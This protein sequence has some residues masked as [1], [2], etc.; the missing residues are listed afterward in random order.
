MQRESSLVA[1]RPSHVAIDN[2]F[3]LCPV[4]TEL[5]R[6]LLGDVDSPKSDASLCVFANYAAYQ[7]G[8]IEADSPYFADLST[9]LREFAKRDNRYAVFN[10]QVGG[11]TDSFK[12][13]QDRSE[14]IAKLGKKLAE[15]AGFKRSTW[16]VTY[17][18]ILD[19]SPHLAKIE[20]AAT[21]A[22]TQ[23]E[24]AIGDERVSVFPVRTFLS[25]ILI[26]NADC[27]VNIRPIWQ[28]TDGPG[29]V[30]SFVPSLKQFI[31]EIK[32]AQKGIDDGS[33]SIC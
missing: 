7:G 33:H 30:E 24:E 15:D 32:Y 10:V 2:R 19:W 3:V 28:K 23:V 5:Q 12:L 14:E 29:F 11:I 6:S 26:Q 25:R 13:T 8:T 17:G 31:P 9:R 27:V 1:E 18:E 16:S 21:L 22:D 20:A 4:T